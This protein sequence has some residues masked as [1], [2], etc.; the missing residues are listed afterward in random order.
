MAYTETDLQA[1]VVQVR[2]ARE[3]IA[4][5]RSEIET[6]RKNRQT[7]IET[8]RSLF[9]LLATLDRIVEH[10]RHVRASLAK[11]NPSGSDR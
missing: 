4:A 7:T 1:A 8:E 11:P 2:Q 9:A 5:L 10:E 3:R 6:A